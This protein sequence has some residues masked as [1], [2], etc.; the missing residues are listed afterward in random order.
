MRLPSAMYTKAEGKSNT[1]FT[2]HKFEN[3][4]ASHEKCKSGKFP[5]NVYHPDELAFSER[6]AQTRTS[7]TSGTELIH[8]NV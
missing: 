7:G 4:V 3:T 2:D 1:D 6:V 8:V 5:L